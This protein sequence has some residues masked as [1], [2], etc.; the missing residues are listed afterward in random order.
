[1]NLFSF[2]SRI[3]TVTYLI[4]KRDEKEHTFVENY[5]KNSFFREATYMDR[6]ISDLSYCLGSIILRY[7]LRSPESLGHWRFEIL[8]FFRI[9]DPL[10]FFVQKN[11]YSIIYT[12]PP[13][14]RILRVI[15]VWNTFVTL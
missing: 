14:S 3:N 12:L 2:S 15:F 6:R 1:M 7:K 4:L 9:L 5:L 11:L 10:L 13:C 8:D